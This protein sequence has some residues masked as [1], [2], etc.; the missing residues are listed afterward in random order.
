MYT[1]KDILFVLNVAIDTIAQAEDAAIAE[2]V[3][4]LQ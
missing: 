1:P 3:E 2:K 4:T